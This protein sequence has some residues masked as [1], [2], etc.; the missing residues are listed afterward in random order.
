M[1]S[2]EAHHTY[3]Q[4][5]LGKWQKDARTGEDVFVEQGI[6]KV[7]K[8]VDYLA[9]ETNLLVVVNT[10]GTP[11]FERQPLRDV[12]VWYGLGEGIH[13]GVLKELA[14]NIQVFDLDEDQSEAL[15]DRIINDF[16]DSYWDVRL[17]DGSPARLA[18]Y[19][20]QTEAMEAMRPYIESV[21]VSRLIDT[22]HVLA[23]H[24]KS[25]EETRKDFYRI[26]NDPSSPHRIILLVN[27]GT[28]GWNC[29]SLF[30]CGLVRKLKSSNNFVLQAAT[31]CLRQV[32]GNTMPARVYVSK[33]NRPI[34]EKQLSETYG[35][36]IADL[37]HDLTERVVK[38]IEVR[39]PVLPPLLIRK[40][41]L[42]FQ[43][44]MSANSERPLKFV[45]PSSEYKSVGHIETWTIA[46]P[47]EGTARFTRVDG[48]EDTLV[49]EP[50]SHTLYGATGEL[51]SNYH[52][53]AGEIL[54]GLREIYS[55]NSLIPAHHVQE[56]GQQIEEQKSDYEEYWEEVDV[57]LALIK[58]D[59]FEK[60][61]EKGQP[62]YTA[63]VSFAKTR[64]HLYKTASELPDDEIARELSFHY[65]GYNFDSRSESDYL[66]RVLNLLQ[67]DDNEI[68][69]IWFTGGLTDPGKTELFAEYL[70]EDNRWHR[71]TPDFVIRR[72]D[73]KHLIVEI[74]SDQY[75]AAVTEDLNR[76]E[77]GEMPITTEGRKAVAL[78]RWQELNPEVL[79]YQVIFADDSLADNALDET[80]KFITGL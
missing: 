40:K 27:M 4:K 32:P 2:D 56:L 16:I 78:K 23:V 71:Y 38:T 74:K 39:K 36:T 17:E 33:G 29:P 62:V 75:N 54:A 65:E 3:G 12:V 50:K 51:A 52:I 53:E 46:E 63:R 22:S 69:G 73:G 41:I 30:A 49:I 37:N 79:H 48:G 47:K 60:H 66:E 35:T 20:P 68:D 44:K 28:E 25:S 31:R 42:R 80:R 8:T 5:L 55:D 9:Q 67:Q 1:F 26:A 61:Y 11:Y 59:G 34:L 58:T 45:T 6:K 21:L 72:K 13:D 15:L 18:L 10:T 77:K 19:F 64:A 24:S 57:A 14:N 7:R 43:R 76:F 70:G